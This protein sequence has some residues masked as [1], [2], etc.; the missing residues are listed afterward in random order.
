LEI[1]GY[2]WFGDSKDIY[3]PLWWVVHFCKRYNLTVD[4]K[5]VE[6]YKSRCEAINCRQRVTI[7]TRS[8]LELQFQGQDLH[9]VVDEINAGKVRGHDINS[10]ASQVVITEID[11]Y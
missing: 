11:P 1:F 3:D 5:R 2:A 9:M 6:D 10:E 8:Q 7:Y 4:I